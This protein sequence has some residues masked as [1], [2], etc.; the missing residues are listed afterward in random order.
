MVRLFCSR[1]TGKPE[2]M[3]TDLI[4]AIASGLPIRALTENR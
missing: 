3:P 4:R 1:I 2:A